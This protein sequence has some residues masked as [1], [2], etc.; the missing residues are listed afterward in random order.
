MHRLTTFVH[1][2]EPDGEGRTGVFGPG[3]DLPD[4][5]VR[6]ITN[7][8]VWDGPVP[9]HIRSGTAPQTPSSE[10]D[11]S[12]TEVRRPAKGASKDDWVAYLL[13]MGH[14]EEALGQLT[15]DGLIELAGQ[16]Q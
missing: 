7:P 4:W 3:D 11:Q 13:A 6:S 5:A 12:G 9:P 14:T 8:D 15:K 1:V 16:P 10:P 2:T